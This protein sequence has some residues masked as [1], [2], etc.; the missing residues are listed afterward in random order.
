MTDFATHRMRSYRTAFNLLERINA[1]FQEMFPVVDA[2]VID[3][4]P[5]RSLGSSDPSMPYDD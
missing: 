5:V 1:G 3:A 2:E 4:E